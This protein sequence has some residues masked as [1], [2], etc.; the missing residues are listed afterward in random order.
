MLRTGREG[1]AFREGDPEDCTINNGSGTATFSGINLIGILGNCD[2]LGAVEV[3][4]PLPV[5][6]FGDGLEDPGPL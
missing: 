3:T 6:M 1:L 2:D 5:R 4:E